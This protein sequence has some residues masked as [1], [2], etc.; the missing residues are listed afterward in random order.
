MLFVKYGFSLFELLC[1]IVLF[2]K[3]WRWMSPSKQ[4][5]RPLIYMAAVLLFIAAFICY[6]WL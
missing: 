1:A 5:Q 2:L 4:N 6:I 3:A